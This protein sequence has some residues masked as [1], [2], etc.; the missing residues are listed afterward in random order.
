[1]IQTLKFA[2]GR[3]ENI[4]GKEER[5]IYITILT[6]TLYQTTFLFNFSKFK[7]FT[8]NKIN[9]IQT[10]KFALGRVENIVRKKKII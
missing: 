7:A 3:V 9:V 8:E 2:L 10:L 5:T 6:L 1:M 4:V